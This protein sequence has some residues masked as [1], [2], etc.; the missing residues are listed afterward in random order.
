MNFSLKHIISPGI[1]LLLSTWISEAQIVK[2][3]SVDGYLGAKSTIN[4]KSGYTGLDFMNYIENYDDYYID[5]FYLNFSSHFWMKNNWEADLEIGVGSSLIPN[6]LDLRAIKR[7]NKLGINFGFENLPFFVYEAELY[8]S[9]TSTSFYINHHPDLSYSYIQFDLFLF[10]PY[11]GINY[12]FEND[13]IIFR[14]DINAGFSFNNK[15]H[16]YVTLKE[17]NSNYIWSEEYKIKSSPAIWINPEIYL[18]IR[19]FDFTN[20][21]IGARISAGYYATHKSLSYNYTARQWTFENEEK[22]YRDMPAHWLQ[23]VNIDAG[24]S[25]IF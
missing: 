7:Y 4:Q 9:E 22:E 20:F 21:D 15:E 11:T 23:Q 2:R 18:F 24:L 5:E 17:K 10:G 25:F 16:S 19:L 6:R 8:Y 13:K 1:I 3:Y 14:G 12:T